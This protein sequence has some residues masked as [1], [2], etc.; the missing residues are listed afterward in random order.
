MDNV[1]K[2]EGNKE[3]G[4][5]HWKGEGGREKGQG[6]VSCVR[7]VHPYGGFTEVP[8]GPASRASAR[9]RFLVLLRG[10]NR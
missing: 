3:N 4:K 10:N 2:K 6:E 7:Y 8:F 9:G 5:R 1:T